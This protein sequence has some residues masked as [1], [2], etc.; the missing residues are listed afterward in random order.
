MAPAD[1]MELPPGFAL[2]RRQ[3]GQLRPELAVGHDAAGLVHLLAACVEDDGGRHGLHL[4]GRERTGIDRVAGRIPD[5]QLAQ[6]ILSVLMAAE[7]NVRTDVEPHEDG[8]ALKLVGHALKAGHLGAAGRALAGEEIEHHWLALAG[9]ARELSVVAAELVVA[10]VGHD[11][12]LA[13][14]QG[15]LLAPRGRAGAPRPKQQDKTAR[16]ACESQAGKPD[17][18]RAPGAPAPAATTLRRRRFG[19]IWLY[20]T[21][22]STAAGCQCVLSSS[23]VGGRPGGV[24]AFY[25]GLW[26]GGGSVGGPVRPF[27]GPRAGGR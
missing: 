25:G 14:S 16:H 18:E 23:A 9:H 4:V 26:V 21:R 6:Q 1:D 7:L 8:L 22:S 27:V 20:G 11:F 24:L 19:G 13:A 2:P 17:Q 12:E 3:L 10:L 15:G 5:M